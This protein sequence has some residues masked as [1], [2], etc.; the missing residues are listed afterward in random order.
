[1]TEDSADDWLS[2]PETD[3]AFNNALTRFLTESDRGAVLIAAETVSNHLEESFRH[4]SP[5]FFVPRLRTILNYPGALSSLSSRA[6]AAAL[7]GLLSENGYNA[8]R[9]LRRIRNNAAHSHGDF[10]L[11]AEAQRMKEMLGHLGDNIPY[12]L[13]NMGMGILL[14]IA[15][16]SLKKSGVEMAT[17]FGRNPFETDEQIAESVKDHPNAKNLLEQRLPRMELGLAIWLLI[18]LMTL[19]RDKFV[20]RLKP[21]SSQTKY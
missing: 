9:L 15:F 16:D 12:A 13:R 2:N 1:V 14:R 8:I 5:E 17:K 18:G 20:A 7:I 6:D 21:P 19:Q 4:L 3:A 10:T 11:T